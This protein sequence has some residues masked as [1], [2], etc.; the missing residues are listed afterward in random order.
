MSLGKFL[1]GSQQIKS[2][3]GTLWAANLANCLTIGPDGSNS[4]YVCNM[5]Y[6][7]ISST[8]RQNN[9][10]SLTVMNTFFP[11]TLFFLFFLSYVMKVGKSNST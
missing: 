8:R 9:N 5:L 10:R 4:D 2:N 6:V 11:C 7:V 3:I 1:E